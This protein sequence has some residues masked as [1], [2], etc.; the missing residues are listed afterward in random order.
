MTDIDTLAQKWFI[1]PASTSNSY[2]PTRRH[3]N[4]T[5]PPY[6]TGNVVRPL[7]GGEAIVKYWGEKVAGLSTD[8]DASPEESTLLHAGW[9]IK[10]IETTLGDTS[11]ESQKLLSDAQDNGVD[12]SLMFSQHGLNMEG[13][14]T[15]VYDLDLEPKTAAVDTRYPSFGCA[16]AKFS[17]FKT[18]EEHTALVGSADIWKSARDSNHEVTVEIEGPAVDDFQT[19][20]KK[21]WNDE[22]RNDVIGNLTYPTVRDS[23]TNTLFGE[24]PDILQIPDAQAT[25]SGS[26]AVQ[27][28]ETYGI[29]P[30]LSYSWADSGEGEFTIW[31][32][33]LKAI[34]NAEEFIYLEDQFFI[35]FGYPPRCEKPPRDVAKGYLKKPHWKEWTDTEQKAS[36]FY[37]IGKRLKDG[38]DVIIL[39]NEGYGGSSMLAGSPG[40][41]DAAGKYLRSIGA[42]YLQKIADEDGSG[43]F[44]IGVLMNEAVHSK[45]LIVDDIYAS[46]GSANI[47]R[48]SHMH[49]TELQVGLVDA[50]GELV[51]SLRAEIWAKH[52]I[53]NVPS[54]MDISIALPAFKDT[55]RNNAANLGMVPPSAITD[56]GEPPSDMKSRLMTYDPA[57]GPEVPE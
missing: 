49:D 14:I 21:R 32:A 7:V 17:V 30:S 56:P 19:V 47:N 8:T 28:L 24:T 4:S 2:P 23:I 18:P 46:V 33:Y 55:L 9:I 34:Q 6:T 37:Q 52:M 57:A 43:D 44:M 40:P 1:D 5:L 3:P 13:I 31:A 35:P 11:T 20:F 42:D 27:V 38:V 39:T 16:H 48:R 45:L 25:D 29:S 12:V 54:L 22:T 26:V 51:P 36:L 53:V 10:N 50:Q 41:L 15:Y